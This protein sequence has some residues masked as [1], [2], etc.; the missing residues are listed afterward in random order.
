MVYLGAY[1]R[2]ETRTIRRLLRPGMCFVDVGANVGYFSLLASRRVGRGGRV[3][4]IEP[5]AYA[6]DR[7]A[8]T[9]RDNAITNIQLARIGVGAAAGE[10]TLF[11]PLPGNH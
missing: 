9:I 10:V 5:S 2:W 1:E 11:D 6:A 7:L 4:A 3:L 8:K